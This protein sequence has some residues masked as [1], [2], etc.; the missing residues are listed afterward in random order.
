MFADE[1]DSDELHDMARAVGMRREWF[2]RN[3][4]DLVPPKRALAVRMGAVEVTDQQSIDIWEKQR[5]RRKVNYVTLPTDTIPGRPSWS[6]RMV[7]FDTETTGTDEN[8]RIVEIGIVLWEDGA[9][10]C[11]FPWLLNPGDVNMD[12][13]DVR[14]AFEVNHIDPASLKD[15]PTFA[16]VF[17]EVRHALEQADT[18]CAH[19]A[20]FDQ[21][22]LRQE[23]KRAVAEG[24]LPADA[25][26]LAP[27]QKL[28][29]L[30]TLGLDLLLNPR[31]YRRNLA[32]V[33]ERWGVSGWEK[34]R[35]VGDAEAAVRILHAMAPQLPE[36]MSEKIPQMREAQRMHQKGIEEWLRKKK[37]DEARAAAQREAQS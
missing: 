26:K 25:L 35:A 5:G 9:V 2:Q 30:C 34:H 20:A 36:D 10:V 12:D 15:K 13:P 37:Q 21:R 3:H 7:G 17:P 29:T 23:F 28:V 11:S 22:M 33:G 8:A 16:E 24:K 14:R 32:T 4:Y 18:R 31:A 1:E 27:E 19:N 6:R